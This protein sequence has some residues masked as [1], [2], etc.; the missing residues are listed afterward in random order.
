GSSPGPGTPE[1]AVP[2]APAPPPSPGAVLPHPVTTSTAAART[3]T[4]PANRLLISGFPH[5]AVHPRESSAQHQVVNGL[6]L[7][8]GD[9]A[10]SPARRAR[11]SADLT[12][13]PSAI[14]VMRPTTASTASTAVS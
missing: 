12:S 4:R 13:R 3:A 2:S 10:A 6:D 8:A 5:A 1:V 14:A 11:A 9:R 7:Q